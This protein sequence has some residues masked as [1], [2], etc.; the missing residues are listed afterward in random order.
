MKTQETLEIESALVRR[1]QEKIGCYGVLEVTI[2][3]IAGGKGY[4]RCDYIEFDTAGLIICYE[5]KVTLPDLMSNN[6]LSYVGDKNYLVVPEELAKKLEEID[7][8]LGGTG[9]IIF[10]GE[11]LVLKKRA[12]KKV[13]GIGE[14]AE[15]LEGI[16]KAACR[17][18]GKY[19]LCKGK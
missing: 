9:L 16:A 6:K 17:D 19:Y 3:H 1:T 11:K 10:N 13:V 15:L 5:I 18:A 7:Y 4:D 12:S 2:G 14:K 8:N